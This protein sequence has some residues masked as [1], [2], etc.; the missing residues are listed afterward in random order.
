MEVSNPRRLLTIQQ[1]NADAL[2][3]LKELTGSTPEQSGD[4]LAG[5]SHSWKIN[6][7]YYT[8]TIPIW[9]DE[10]ISAE[11][12]SRE[13]LKP[14]AKEVLEVLGAIVLCFRTPV[15]VNELGDVKASI[16]A[17]G[18]VVGS[19]SGYSWDGICLAVEMQRSIATTDSAVQLPTAEEWDD[20]CQD[21]GFEYVDLNAK[22]RNEFGEP[23][24]L[25][26]VIEALEANDWAA[27]QLGLG[28]EDDEHED[29][30][31]NTGFDAEATEVE[32]EVFGLKNALREALEDHDGQ[33][34]DDEEGQVEDLDALFGHVLAIRDSTAH[35]PPE[36]RKKA[37]RDMLGGL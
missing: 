22:G 16:K 15:S 19:G 14:E 5:L 1:P 32:G 31:A 36:E 13:W 28:D 18:Q 21:H 30:E 17:I 3:F 29:P 8:A 37:V 25:P 9:I 33:A 2:A 7:Q 26:R 34:G 35:L 12:W 4:S 27:P 23:V 11:E 10:I 24:G 20:S 6:T